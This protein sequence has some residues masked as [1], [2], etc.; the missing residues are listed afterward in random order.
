MIY[1]HPS[2]GPTFGGGHDISIC[3]NSNTSNSSCNF[4]HSYE[5]KGLN[6][7]NLSGA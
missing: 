5:S 1:C 4:N 3:N 6:Y 7:N 2:F